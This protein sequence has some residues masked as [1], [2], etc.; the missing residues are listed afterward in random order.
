MNN[1]FRKV[2]ISLSILWRRADSIEF[3]ENYIY[4]HKLSEVVAHL[5]TCKGNM[6]Q[7]NDFFFFRL[8]L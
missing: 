8:I 6:L 3:H 1:N 5:Y 4:I 2:A 7:I